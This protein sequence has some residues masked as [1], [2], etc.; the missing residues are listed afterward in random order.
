MFHYAKNNLYNPITK[1]EHIS[2]TVEFYL[3]NC[4]IPKTSCTKKLTMILTDLLHILRK[5]QPA[6]QFLAAGTEF[7]ELILHLRKILKLPT[8]PHQDPIQLMNATPT[9]TAPTTP[10]PTRTQPQPHHQ[11][12]P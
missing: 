2:N 12:H 1:R 9:A 4:T 3:H 5:P 11:H 7:N 8:K 10:P 6:T